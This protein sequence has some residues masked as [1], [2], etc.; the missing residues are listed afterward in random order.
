MSPLNARMNP[1]AV[2]QLARVCRTLRLRKEFCEKQ[3]HHQNSP[4]CGFRD[5]DHALIHSEFGEAMVSLSAK[6]KGGSC[7]AVTEP[8]FLTVM[9]LARGASA[10]ERPFV[11]QF[12]VEPAE[13]MT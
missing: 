4:Q 5:A 3:P 8:A 12:C 9:G 6:C 13:R 11:L 1:R 7:E 10:R 2:K